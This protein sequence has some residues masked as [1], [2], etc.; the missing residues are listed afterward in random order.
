MKFFDVFNV[1]YNINPLNN[2]IWIILNI[3]WNL[4]K[5]L[6]I[7]NFDSLKSSNKFDRKSDNKNSK[8]QISKYKKIWVF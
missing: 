7:E 2:N 5:K 4:N 3:F 6:K 1:N 8:D